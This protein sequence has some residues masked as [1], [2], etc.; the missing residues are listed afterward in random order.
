MPKIIPIY[1]SGSEGL[2]DEPEVKVDYENKGEKIIITY[3]FPGYSVSNVKRKVNNNWKP[4]REVGMSGTG[5]YSV[6]T[7]PLLPSFGRFVQIP[8]NYRVVKVRSRRFNPKPDKKY[9]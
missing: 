9:T 8:I 1:G 5:F 6:D 4:F 2:S 3:I 7:D